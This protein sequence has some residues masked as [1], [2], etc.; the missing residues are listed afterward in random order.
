MMARRSLRAA[1]ATVVLATAVVSACGEVTSEPIYGGPPPDDSSAGSG[2]SAG[3]NSAGASGSAGSP[4]GGPTWC[5]SEA[6]QDHDDCFAPAGTLCTYDDYQCSCFRSEWH[7]LE[8]DP[9]CPESAGDAIWDAS[10]AEPND[11]FCY[12]DDAVC[13]CSGNNY[14]CVFYG[15]PCPAVSPPLNTVCS[16][17]DEIRC[18]YEFG[19]CFCDD[20]SW[21]CPR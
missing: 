20:G 8:R 19:V 15:P 7:C 6:P 17:R 21:R 18:A 4:P 11:G 13:F 16:M 10:C 3:Q 1:I 12:Y 5:P 14:E 2:G 9:N